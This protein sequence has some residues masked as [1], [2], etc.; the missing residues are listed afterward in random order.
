MGLTLC[1]SVSVKGMHTLSE[2]ESWN[3]KYSTPCINRAAGKGLKIAQPAGFLTLYIRALRKLKPPPR[4]LIAPIAR[5]HDLESQHS[6][7]DHPRT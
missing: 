7:P 2:Q 3:D 6:D 4:Q 5:I 1:C